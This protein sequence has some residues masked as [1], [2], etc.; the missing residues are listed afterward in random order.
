MPFKVGKQGASICGLR[1]PWHSGLIY[2]ICGDAGSRLTSKSNSSFPHSSKHI[3]A[4]FIYFFIL[5]KRQF[6]SCQVGKI[7]SFH[8]Q[9]NCPSKVLLLSSE[10]LIGLEGIHT[11]WQRVH[12]LAWVTYTWADGYNTWHVQS[13][14]QHSNT[15]QY[16]HD[17]D[18]TEL[19]FGPDLGPNF[20]KQVV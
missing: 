9:M 19:H 11:H 13:Q 20:E 15:R 14:M 17:P 2:F 5:K 10:L 18:R 7:D 16:T 3:I 1:C 12:T 6:A 8:L 4:A